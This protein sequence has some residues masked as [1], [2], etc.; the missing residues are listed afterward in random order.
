MPGL[1]EEISWKSAE[2][3]ESTGMMRAP[4]A[5]ASAVT[6]SP[7][8]TRLSL[9]ASARSMPSPSAAI[10]GPSPAEPIS[11]FSTRSQSVSVISS[12]RPSAPASTSPS[13]HS[14]EALAAASTRRP[15]RCAPRR[16][17]R[18]ARSAAPSCV[19]AARPDDLELGAALHHVERLGADRPG[20]PEDDDPRTRS[21]SRSRARPSRWRLRA[22]SP[23]G[24]RARRRP[25]WRPPPGR[26]GPRA[27]AQ[28]V[29]LVDPQRERRRLHRDCPS[30]ACAFASTGRVAPASAA[31]TA[32]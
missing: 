12:I 5:S 32:R 17:R 28:S 20:R 31:A 7:P 23:H 4:V 15:A 26:P 6:S 10:V 21:E 22:G 3:S 19:A 14:S 16:E 18:P 11:P 24:G 30:T 1:S 29:A 8:T 27:A 13:V 9:L 2:C 25:S